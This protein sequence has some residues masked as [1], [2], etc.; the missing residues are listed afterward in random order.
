ME[1]TIVERIKYIIKSEGL[2]QREMSSLTGIKAANLNHV[3]KGRNKASRL[4]LEKILSAFPHYDKNWLYTG[5][6]IPLRE[7]SQGGSKVEQSQS[8][9][10]PIDR[11]SLPNTSLSTSSLSGSIP[12]PIV[13]NEIKYRDGE[14]EHSQSSSPNK[15][16]PTKKEYSVIETHKKG[17]QQRDITANHQVNKKI[18]K[19]IIYFEDNTFEEFIPSSN[20]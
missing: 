20:I 13:S 6:G 15:Q 3:L 14:G 8:A 1:Y 19:I 7:D 2:S 11:S 5:V 18:K 17:E 10:F 9:L 4:F 16:I 12:Y